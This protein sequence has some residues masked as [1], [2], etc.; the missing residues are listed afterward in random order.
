M[1]RIKFQYREGDIDQAEY[2][3]ELGLTKAALEAVRTPDDGDLIRLGDHIEGLIEAWTLATNEERH[4]LLTMML[5][6]V[7]VD[8]QSG[9]FEGVKPKPE[10]LPLFNLAEP[11]RAGETVL[12]AALL[13]SPPSPPSYHL[14]S[15]LSRAGAFCA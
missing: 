1:Q 14:A 7:Y 9:T 15:Q 13:D 12:V 11:V 8:M 10:F 6:A 3:Q 5:D 2:Q 4:Q